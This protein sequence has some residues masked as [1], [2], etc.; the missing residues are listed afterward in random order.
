MPRDGRDEL[1]LVAEDAGPVGDLLKLVAHCLASI[2]LLGDLEANFDDLEATLGN[3]VPS[4]GLE[5]MDSSDQLLLH[6]S[7]AAEASLDLSKTVL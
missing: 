6:E 5:V 7:G 1:G 4:T 3:V 2:D